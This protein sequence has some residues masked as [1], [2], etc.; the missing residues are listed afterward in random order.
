MN[1]SLNDKPIR[2]I[3]QSLASFMVAALM[4]AVLAGC[5]AVGPNYVPPQTPFPPPGTPHCRGGSRSRP[6]RGTSRPG[7]R[8]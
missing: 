7:G 1:R 4:I 6:I 2:V 3:L 8:P 5:A